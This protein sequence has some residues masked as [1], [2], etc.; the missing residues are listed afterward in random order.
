MTSP[1]LMKSGTLMLAPVPILTGLVAPVAVSLDE[2]RQ[3]DVDSPAVEEQHL[4]VDV[5]GHEG[6][7]IAD[8]LARD[9]D[10]VVGGRVHEDERIRVGVEVLHRLGL[11]VRGLEPLARAQVPLED[12]AGEQVLHL[13]PRER[14]ALAGL[15]EL[16]LDDGVGR[17]VDHDLQPL[18]DVGRVVHGEGI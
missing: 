6:G 9:L 15:D 17:A 8:R 12:V 10:L 1:T 18:A 11:D 2:V 4:D 16:E 13:G 14:R 7:L 5:L 3:R